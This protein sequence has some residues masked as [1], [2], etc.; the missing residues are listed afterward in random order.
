MLMLMLLLLLVLVLVLPHGLLLHESAA[1]AVA[2]VGARG[3]TTRVAEE[4]LTEGG[5]EVAEAAAK[6]AAEAIA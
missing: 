4:T 2:G 3:G 1:V 5:G 6:A